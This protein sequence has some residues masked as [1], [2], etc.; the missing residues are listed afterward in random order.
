MVMNS[1]PGNVDSAAISGGGGKVPTL[2]PD[3][4]L[5]SIVPD[6]SIKC[7]SQNSVGSSPETQ[8][9]IL[10]SGVVNFISFGTTNTSARDLTLIIT[11]DGAE[12]Y[13]QTL[14]SGV[15]G[16]SLIPIGFYGDDGGVGVGLSFTPTTFSKSLKVE[17][18]STGSTNQF[19]YHNYYLT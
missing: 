9:E 4:P 14:S 17:T 2:I 1:N 19:F 7:I 16:G 6:S 13:N 15:S 8:L 18:D 10:G 12:V 5:S 11:I 3:R